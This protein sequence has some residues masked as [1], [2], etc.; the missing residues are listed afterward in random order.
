MTVQGYDPRTGA[1]VGD[2]VAETTAASLED[3]L[4]AAAAA[5]PAFRSTPPGVRADFL[6]LLAGRLDEA[7]GELVPLAMAESGLPVLE[8]PVSPRE[9]RL[10][11][12][13]FKAAGD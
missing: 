1:P 5:F 6:T 4:A 2:G 9:L 10:T 12:A 11:L 7:A 13:L 8:K 3:L